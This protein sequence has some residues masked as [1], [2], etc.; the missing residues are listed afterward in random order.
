MGRSISEVKAMAT[1]VDTQASIANVFAKHFDDRKN[2]FL[3]SLG[4]ATRR[5]DRTIFDSNIL[6]YLEYLRMMFL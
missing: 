5:V 6:R 2:S 1:R 3:F 4:R